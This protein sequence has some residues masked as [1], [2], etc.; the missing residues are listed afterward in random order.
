MTSSMLCVLMVNDTF[1]PSKKLSSTLASS[2]KTSLAITFI[3][4]PSAILATS[5]PIL[6]KPIIPRVLPLSSTPF[7]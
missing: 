3:P 2:T 1:C 4:T 5:T 7:A 6:P